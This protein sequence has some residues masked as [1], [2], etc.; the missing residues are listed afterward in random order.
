MKSK[1][2]P[3]SDPFVIIDLEGTASRL[4]SYAISQSDLVIIPMKEQQQDALTALDVIQETHRDMKATRR[5]IP[6]VVLFTQSR[7]AVKSRTARHIAQQFKGNIHIDT[8]TTEI[9]ESDAFAAMFS[10][11]G[12]VAQIRERS[13]QGAGQHRDFP[14]RGHRPATRHS[15]RPIRESSMSDREALAM[16]SF[17]DLDDLDDFA[18]RGRAGKPRSAPRP[19]HRPHPPTLALTLLRAPSRRPNQSLAPPPAAPTL[20]APSTR[21]HTSPR[22]RRQ[23][24]GS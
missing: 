14:H 22:G 9:H 19:R 10:M 11:G 12:H 15:R 18:P 24:T 1:P 6:Y 4:M 21:C 23:T 17:D 5:K 16:P 20:S 3:R 13:G 2:R 7:A 8:F